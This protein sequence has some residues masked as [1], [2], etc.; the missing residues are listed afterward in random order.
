MNLGDVIL[1]QGACT[2]SAVN[3][4][5]FQGADFAAEAA[6]S[7]RK[8]VKPYRRA[9]MAAAA[10]GEIDL[11]VTT[12]RLEAVRWLRRVSRHVNRIATHL[13]DVFVEEPPPEE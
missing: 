12:R 9:V 5:R 13:A 8:E 10:A 6:E 7:I 4:S 11:N 2:D 1:A 3:R